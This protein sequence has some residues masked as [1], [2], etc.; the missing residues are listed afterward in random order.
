VIAEE[1]Q[2]FAHDDANIRRLCALAEV[3]R[4]SYYRRRG[5]HGAAR[6]DADLR[7]LIHRIALEDRH[8]GY[9]RV[10]R[11]LFRRGVVV[12][13][14]RVAR[15][16]REDNLLALRGK[17]F[18]PQTTMSKHDCP[19]RPN[20]VRGLKPTGLD[21]IWVAD[22]T[23][24]RLAEAF[25]Y[26][27]VIL[28]AFSRKVIGWALADHL[29]ASLALA[30]L[31]MALA[32]RDPAPGSLIHHSDRGVQYASN[33][34]VERLESRGVAISMSRPA[35]PYDNAKA[36]SFMKTLKAEEVNGAIYL[37]LDDAERH[38]GAFI[39]TVYNAKRLHS[40]LGYK[41]PQEFEAEIRQAESQPMRSQPLSL[42]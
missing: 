13:H 30:A 1:P 40:A 27:A 22:I 41:P 12:N 36:E 37:D 20:L 7:D 5:P 8:Y 32:A 34:Y 35:N 17:P 31:D 10:K 9:R 24:V 2:G 15:L 26:L 4:A 28:D 39:E 29:Q 25:V 18:V 19:I 3:S 21:Q 16:M 23:Y 6:E 38:I 42:N 33:L 14:K 11:E